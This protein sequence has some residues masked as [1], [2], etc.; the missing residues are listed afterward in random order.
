MQK[1]CRKDWFWSTFFLNKE[2]SQFNY[3]LAFFIFWISV[4]LGVH[5]LADLGAQ[6]MT[7]L[8]HLVRADVVLHRVGQIPH[9][10]FGHGI[11]VIAVARS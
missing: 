4:E 8:G 9:Q 2:A 6:V 1:F 7:Y 11:D 5:P 10:G 3:W